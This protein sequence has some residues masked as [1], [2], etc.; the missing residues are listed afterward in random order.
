VDVRRRSALVLASAWLLMSMGSWQRGAAAHTTPVPTDLSAQAIRAAAEYT[1]ARFAVLGREPEVVLSRPVL[2]S[3]LPGLG[4]I[5]IRRPDDA[6]PLQLVI[7][8]GDFG[9]TPWLEREQYSPG[10]PYLSQLLAGYIA[11]VLDLH[12]LRPLLWETSRNGGLLRAAL[13]DPGL[14][15]EVVPLSESILTAPPPGGS[16]WPALP[17]P[18]PGSRL[19]CDQ[20]V[21]GGSWCG[22]APPCGDGTGPLIGSCGLSAPVTCVRPGA[23]V[24]DVCGRGDPKHYVEIA[25]T[26]HGV[27]PD[28]L[29]L[30]YRTEVLWINHGSRPHTVTTADGGS[31]SGAIAP[32][33]RWSLTFHHPIDFRYSDRENPD[34]LRGRLKVEGCMP[35]ATGMHQA[36]RVHCIRYSAQPVPFSPDAAE[37]A[38]QR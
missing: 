17:T 28:E 11:Y 7:V 14:P 38:L 37:Y 19:P 21:P 10:N 25:I 5:D 3:E 27:R 4:L 26:D 20:P 31:D 6:P 12:S 15:D 2:A 24:P 18:T 32:G 36:P 34:A 29:T 23:V 33:G 9:L 35:G 16:H 22:F 13:E 1:Y 30:P 8:R